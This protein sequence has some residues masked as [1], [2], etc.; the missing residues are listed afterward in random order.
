ML[1]SIIQKEMREN[2][3]SY[4][5]SIIVIVST[6]LILVSIFVMYHDYCLALENYEILYPKS[7]EAITAGV[8]FVRR[9]GK[10]AEKNFEEKLDNLEK[11]VADM[12][13]GELSLS[14]M[15]KKFEDGMKLARNC[16]KEID[17]A[18]K[19]IE[20]LRKKDGA[21]VTENFLVEDEKH[22]N[23]SSGVKNKN[24]VKNKPESDDS[25]LMF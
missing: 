11:I 6:L 22:E 12:E 3:F 14:A 16:T 19:K 1:R 24:T 9:K 21:K 20:I 4:K 8:V 13:K 18:E 10:M 15:L 23:S 25:D 2:L 17:Q 7:N 5:F